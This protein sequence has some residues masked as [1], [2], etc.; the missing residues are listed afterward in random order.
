MSG[1]VFEGIDSHR[2]GTRVDVPVLDYRQHQGEDLAEMKKN[3][4][5]MSL[6]PKQVMQDFIRERTVSGHPFHSVWRY[7]C[8]CFS[9]TVLSAACSRS[10]SYSEWGIVITFP[11]PNVFPSVL[12]SDL[13]DCRQARRP[14]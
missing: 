4:S 10:V 11:S 7:P 2:R 13:M 6:S 14:Q 3:T 12:Y 1:S 9:E 5:E 8:M